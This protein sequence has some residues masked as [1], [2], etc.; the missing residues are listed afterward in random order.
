M[1]WPIS[2]HTHQVAVVVDK[3]V[4][5]L[6]VEEMLL[7]LWPERDVLARKSQEA[8][9]ISG[10]DLLRGHLH[11]S[12][13]GGC[14]ELEVRNRIFR[15][16]AAGHLELGRLQGHSEVG[17]DGRGVLDVRGVDLELFAASSRELD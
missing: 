14:Q 12:Q 8:E 15:G 16:D 10:R 17:V 13:L 1:F 11:L 7:G 4:E 9:R 6:R 2:L 5:R 3:D